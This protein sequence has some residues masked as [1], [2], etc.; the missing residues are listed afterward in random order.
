MLSREKEAKNYPPVGGRREGV[1]NEKVLGLFVGMLI[2][3]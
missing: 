2:L 1:K 3:Y